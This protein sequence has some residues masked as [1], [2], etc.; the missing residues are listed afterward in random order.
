MEFLGPTLDLNQVNELLKLANNTF[1]KKLGIKKKVS[2][3]ANIKVGK[4][5]DRNDKLGQHDD[6]DY[7][8]EEGEEEEEEVN[9]NMDQYYK[10]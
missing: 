8:D 10:K 1:N 3:K 7:E 5:M 2:G 4:I 6:Y 9:D